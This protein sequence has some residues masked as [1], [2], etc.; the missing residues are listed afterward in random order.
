MEPEVSIRWSK[1]HAFILVL[2]AFILVLHALILVLHAL[3]L[4][5]SHINSVRT[6]TPI[7]LYSLSLISSSHLRLGLLDIFFL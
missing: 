2:H 1:K 3:T 6:F 5:L 4:V 7:S